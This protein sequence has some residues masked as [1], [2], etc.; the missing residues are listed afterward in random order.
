M[1]C[2]LIRT[3]LHHKL[4]AF[5]LVFIMRWIAYQISYKKKLPFI[6]NI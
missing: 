6:K 2:Q 3:L 5:N 4:L 1:L